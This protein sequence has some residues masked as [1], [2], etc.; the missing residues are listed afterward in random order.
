MNRDFKG[1]WIPDATWE[2]KSLRAETK[3]LFGVILLLSIYGK[4]IY[5]THKMISEAFNFSING[6]KS[7]IDELCKSRR[8]VKHMVKP[9]KKT[10]S[11]LIDEYGKKCQWCGGKCLI[12]HSHHHPIK[13]SEGG[14]ITVDICPNCHSNFHAVE[15]F[16]S[17]EIVRY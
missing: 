4:K 17:V 3:V 8:L 9:D 13:R 16:N 7:R 10:I 14:V 2:D 11:I 1:I 6:V 5:F 15:D 12:L